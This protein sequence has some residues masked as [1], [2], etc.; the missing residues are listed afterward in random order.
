MT[1]LPKAKKFRIRRSGLLA[2]GVS[3]EAETTAPSYDT[4]QATAR[5]TM[6][7]EMS[8]AGFRLVKA[9]DYLERQYFLIFSAEAVDPEQPVR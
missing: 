4:A 8:A 5:E 2:S 9:H 1:T 7:E 3:R 6:E